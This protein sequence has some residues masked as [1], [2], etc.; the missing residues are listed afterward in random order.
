MALK[1]FSNLI[2][3]VISGVVSPE[4][5]QTWTNWF[6]QLCIIE[7]WPYGLRIQWTNPASLHK[8]CF[9]I[10]CASLA[11]VTAGGRGLCTVTETSLSSVVNKQSIWGLCFCT[12]PQNG[13][14]GESPLAGSLGGQW[15][16]DMFGLRV[17]SCGEN[18]RDMYMWQEYHRSKLSNV[19]KYIWKNAVSMCPKTEVWSSFWNEV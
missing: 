10:L 15:V 2:N 5:N 4:D 19:C 6:N 13:R 12:L 1:V 18:S 11:C 17:S 3:F 14:I 8:P 9:H 7:M 16:Q